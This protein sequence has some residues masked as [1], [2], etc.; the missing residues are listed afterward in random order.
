MSK[1]YI[2]AKI[3]GVVLLVLL[4]MGWGNITAPVN[5]KDGLG[6]F[7][8]VANSTIA[9]D[10]EAAIKP[11]IVRSRL[12]KI[13]WDILA[14]AEDSTGRKIF[15]G[16]VLLLNLFEDRSYTAHL[17]HGQ[18]SS[19][20]HFIWT[21]HIEGDTRSQVTLVVQ[22]DV[23]VGNIRVSGDL[24]QVRYIGGGVHVIREIDERYFPPEAEPIPVDNPPS[25]GE[26]RSGTAADDGSTLDVM[27]VY[28]ERARKQAGGTAAMNALINLAVTE[29]NTAYSNSEVT[30]RLRLVHS[31]EVNYSGSGDLVVDL[32]RLQDT[33]DGFMDNVHTLRNTHGADMVSLF[34]ASGVGRGQA[35]I[36]FTLSHDFHPFAFSVV[37]QN[38]ATVLFIFGHEIGHN[39]GLA[40]DHGGVF[41]Y[42]HGYADSKNHFGTIMSKSCRRCERIQHFSNPSVFFEG[43]STGEDSAD[44]ARSLN[45]TAFTVA[46]W[47]VSVDQ[48]LP[49]TLNSI[50]PNAGPT[51]G[52]TTV[53]LNGTNF[54]DGGTSVSFGG[55]AATNV[56]V[57][58]ATNLTA[59]T[60]PHGEGAVDVVVTTPVGSAT[61]VQAFTYGNSEL[62][63]ISTR[64]LV[65]AGDDV[66]IGGLI[67]GGSTSK[68]VLIRARGPVLADF[69][70]AGVL[71]N[72]LLQLFDD[73]GTVIA[74][75]DDWETTT[76]LCQ[77]S[78]L[79]CGGSAE[80]TATELDPC[81]PIP[82]PGQ[83]S[84]PTGCS[85]ESAILVTLPPGNYTAQV[86]GGTV[87]GNIQADGETG[88]G[89]VEVFEIS[90]ASTSKLTNISTR[91][92][93]GAGDDVMIGGFIIG[94][95][96]PKTVFVRARGPALADFGV[97]GV[98]DDPVLQLF[99]GQT[100]LARNND[101]RT[102]DPLCGAPAVSCG[103]EAEIIA[104]GLDPCQPIELPGHPLTPT[105]CNQE[106]VVLVTL[107][108][109]PYTAIVSGV[110]GGTG[111]GL[112][113]V[114]EVN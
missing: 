92:V 24:Y 26:D 54:V 97:P 108:P 20:N 16:G 76:A 66:M 109:G 33:A 39:T 25:A 58:S 107:P 9:E 14:V 30:P 103:G 65:G 11:T 48:N 79:N 63:N 34:V 93:V 27:V 89:L 49:P 42:S 31:E 81:R 32:Q 100:V 104:T 15:R 51:S 56:S 43:E 96:T 7:I 61:L 67:I 10:S 23:M 90:T 99:S 86:S 18:A 110:N 53:T 52:G 113:E 68:T 37:R 83:P 105:G 17:Y 21:G 106:S 84:I 78:G 38:S 13:D 72:P 3:L 114:F 47:R 41:S 55:D 40:H 101:W 12:V 77:N 94:G 64:G 4:G 95:S 44:A 29:T 60:P 6:L 85:L 82:L 91:G 62:T 102:T 75:N 46:N 57:T 74:N 112:V 28:T 69:G 36:M 8:D 2:R 50:S 98:L 19:E 22:D 88:V 59:I 45:E 80:I 1:A 5:G 35:F 87:N 71:A 70:V 111:V 73:N